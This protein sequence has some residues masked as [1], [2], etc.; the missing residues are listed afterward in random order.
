MRGFARGR[1]AWEM[2]VW[3]AWRSGVARA[4]ARAHCGIFRVS[5]F[6]SLKSVRRAAREDAAKLS[7]GMRNRAM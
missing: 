4:I 1:R 7:L 6:E 5:G 2:R 3:G